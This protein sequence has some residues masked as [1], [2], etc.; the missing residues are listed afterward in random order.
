[1]SDLKHCPHCAGEARMVIF[2]EVAGPETK[3]YYLVECI[4]Q[5]ACGGKLHATS[6]EA[7]DYWN[8]LKC[9]HY[10]KKRYP[11][12]EK[13]YKTQPLSEISRA[14]GKWPYEPDDY[15]EE[16]RLDDLERATDMNNA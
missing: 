15:A 4:A 6:E 2:T 9:T 16:K 5:C 1:M 12:I 7:R 8:S 11:P 10:K 14:K 13:E 3:L